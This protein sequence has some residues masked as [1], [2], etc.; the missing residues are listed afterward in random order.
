L[1]WLPLGAG[2]HCTARN[3]RIF[4]ALMATYERR[5]VRDLYHSAL[6]V[7]LGDDRFVI[8][9]TPVWAGA[10][11][12]RGV[13]RVGP[14]GSR[15]LGRSALFRYEPRT[16]GPRT[17]LGPRREPDRRD[18]ELQLAD[19][20]AARPQRP[21]DGHHRSTRT[22]AGS[23][24]AGRRGRRGPPSGRSR[25]STGE[26]TIEIR[27]PAR[28]T[29]SGRGVRAL[30]SPFCSNETSRFGSDR[31][32]GCAYDGH[33]AAGVVQHSLADGSQEQ[34]GEAA[35]SAGA[36]HQKLCVLRS[37][38]QGCRRSPADEFL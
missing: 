29:L 31:G 38:D 23:R 9:M 4:E 28:E 37:F 17:D 15:L 33:R 2:G 12:D 1:Y 24:M 19:L 14:V 13:V 22:R 21:P 11:A 27:S 3:G 6:E 10:A 18:V 26:V 5:T 25:W 7:R 35:S 30:R 8:E 34:P 20:V 16:V 32:Q 36:G